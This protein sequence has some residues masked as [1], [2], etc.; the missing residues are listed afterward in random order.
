MTKLVQAEMKD[1]TLTTSNFGPL[2]QRKQKLMLAK[3]LT[4][5]GVLFT[6]TL[7]AWSSSAFAN[8]WQGNWDSNFG[9]LRLMQNGDRLFGDYQERGTI[10]GRISRDGRSARAVFVYTDGRWGTV[11]W[12]IA[13][14]KIA[15]T[16][17]WSQ[18]GLPDPKTNSWTATRDTVRTSRLRYASEA[19]IAYPRRDALF[20]QGPV[21]NWLAFSDSSNVAPSPSP[22]LAADPRDGLGLWYGGYSLREATAAFDIEIDIIHFD[23]QNAGA[24]D[25]SI[26]VKRGSQCPP[27]LH[28]AFCDELMSGADSRSYVKATVTGNS[29]VNRSIGQAMWIT[30]QLPGDQRDRLLVIGREATYFTA[31]IHHP[32]RGFDFIGTAIG[33]SHLCEQTACSNDVFIDLRNN[34]NKYRGS[35]D[36]AYTTPVYN[37]PNNIGQSHNTTMRPAPS[38]PSRPMLS[39]AWAIL[40][41]TSENLGTISFSGGGNGI[42]ANGTLNGFFETGSPH[43]TEY[44]FMTST[45]EAVAFS[46]TIFAGQSGERRNGQLIVELPSFARDNPK[47]TLVVGEDVFLVELVRPTRGLDPS[48]VGD[49]PAIGVYAPLYGLRGI[50]SGR[51]IVLRKEASRSS[52]EVGRLRP[53]ARDLTVIRC[54]PDIDSARFDSAGPGG[55]L[56]MLSSSWCQITNNEFA[57]WLPGRY[58]SPQNN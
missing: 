12:R 1:E 49:A 47:G 45:D 41:E 54:T 10:E 56:A 43:E 46:L 31:T 32:R 26:F 18:N 37:L 6:A 25:M 36:S 48:E 17:H 23:G 5:F 30:F 3:F 27:A 39:D 14:D 40:D 19:R 55:K 28:T 16:W 21:Q 33:R 20:D 7:I 53:D 24:V 44:R 11:Q 15:G 4:K 8:N 22:N 9:E 57:G 29:I 13:N 35:Y 52:S 34:P 38:R 51:T 2:L 58:L 42:Q 50:P